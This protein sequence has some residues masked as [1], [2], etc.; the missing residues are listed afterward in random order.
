[1]TNSKQYQISN[2]QMTKILGM[3]RLVFWSFGHWK[4][5]GIWNLEFGI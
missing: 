2:D 3:T 1:M 5:F 4:L